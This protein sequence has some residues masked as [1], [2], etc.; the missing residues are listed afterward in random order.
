MTTCP[1][2]NCTKLSVLPHD[3]GFLLN[4]SKVIRS[5]ISGGITPHKKALRILDNDYA[6]SFD[7]L[8][9]ASDEC[10]IHT[11]NLQNLMIDI[12]KC[13]SNQNKSVLWDVFYDKSDKFDFISKNLLMLPQT[14][15]FRYGY[16][17]I[18]SHVGNIWNYIKRNIK[19]VTSVRNA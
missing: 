19:S 3:F 10:T 18:F 17:D 5:F 15:T 6:V 7:A 1:L 16:D 2:S 11:K 9:H 12:H 14:N 13:T 8:L 4:F